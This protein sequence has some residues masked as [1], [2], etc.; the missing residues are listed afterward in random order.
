MSAQTSLEIAAVMLRTTLK[1]IIKNEITKR[2]EALLVG[3]MMKDI[4]PFAI[5]RLIIRQPRLDIGNP[6]STKADK[7]S[8]KLFV[9]NRSK[10]A[11]RAGTA[12]T[13]GRRTQNEIKR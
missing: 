8:I 3:L 13:E 7:K 5:H 9:A 10:R 12:N 2:I 6:T 4:L 1:S 11:V